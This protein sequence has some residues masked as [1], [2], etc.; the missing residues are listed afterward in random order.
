MSDGQDAETRAFLQERIALLFK[1]MFWS[2]AALVGFLAGLYG[3]DPDNAPD[4]RYTVYALC[5]AGLGA[6]GFI[7]RAVLVRRPVP[8]RTLHA[9]DLVYSLGIGTAFGASAYLQHDLHAAGYLSAIYATFTVFARALIVPSSGRRTLVASSLTFLPLTMAAIALA[10]EYEQDIPGPMFFV[11]YLLFGVLAVALSAYGS[12]VIY[13]LRRDVSEAEQLGQYTLDRKIGEGGMGAVYLAHHVLL[14]RDTAVK[15]IL[16]DRVGAEN[17]E[18]FEREVQHMSQLTHPN[19]VAVYDYGS[20]PDGIFYYAME[21]LGGGIDL[22]NLVRKHGPQPSG[23]VAQILAQACGALH[24]AHTK[25][26]IHRDIKPPNII[27]CERGGMPDVAK[28]VDFG[29]VKDFAANTGA[30]TQVVLG[31][32]A[33]IAPEA[34]TDPTSV[35]PAVDLYAMGCTG[36]FL[37]TGKRVF[38]GKTAVDVCIQHVT[39][40]PTP[41]SQVVE[42]P[43]DPTLEAIIL[44]CLAKLPQ[45]RHANAAELRAAL[46]AVPSKDWTD[47]DARAWWKKFRDIE[48]QV[49]S[50]PDAQTITMTIDLDAKR[51][52][53]T[54]VKSA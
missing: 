54:D 36:Y 12:N 14:R 6:M 26:L 27:L 38:E 1:T 15:R 8:M 21:Y 46:R 43:I 52:A 49:R 13:G 20:T 19:T 16:P 34:V 3:L 35:G 18:R 42:T 29:L 39:K 23:R 2:L 47:A 33:Y 9:L 30:S 22:E 28:V 24:E 32:P 40:P 17:V 25:K 10:L 50:A 31:T 48:Q 5:A 53:S 45:D 37:L 7:W 44:K 41:P 11:G 51:V 4:A